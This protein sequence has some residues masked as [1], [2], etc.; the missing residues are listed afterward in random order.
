FSLGALCYVLLS[1]V[2][3]RKLFRLYFN[4]LITCV[5]LLTMYLGT[6]IFSYTIVEGPMA[7]SHNLALISMLFYFT[8]KWLE[9]P[10]YGLT[11]LLGIIIGLMILIRPTNIIFVSVLILFGITGISDIKDRA[12]LLLNRFLKVLIMVLT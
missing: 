11:I 7:H 5:L 6:N 1:M 4:E 9:K 2:F 10:R 12:K 8:I 3:F